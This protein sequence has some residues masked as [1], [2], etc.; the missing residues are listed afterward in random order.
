MIASYCGFGAGLRHASGQCSWWF[1]A[2][3]ATEKIEYFMEGEALPGC[4][5]RARS[6]ILTVPGRAEFIG[7]CQP[8]AARTR[9]LA[10]GC[11][12]R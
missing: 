2:L 11:A 7:H 1:R 10:A 8:I 6:L 5:R 12:E 9:R 4:R 3:R